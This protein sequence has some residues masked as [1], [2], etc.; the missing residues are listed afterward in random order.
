PHKGITRRNVRNAR[1][2]SRRR[3]MAY[4]LRRILHAC[5]ALLLVSALAFVF[6]ELAPGNFFDE[7]RLNPQ[8]SADSVAG[9][10]AKYGLEQ[11]LAAR[12]G[13]WL[14]SVFRGEFGFSFAYGVPVSALLW[15][16][17]R[18][19]LLLTSIATML[20]W[21]IALLAGALAAAYPS[22]A[23]RKLI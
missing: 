19:T 3:L 23:I 5:A 16:R 20:A 9:L 15:E 14:A 18:N 1:R 17:A 10:K 12:Y 8:I 22:S 21:I 6:T 11:P 4:I 7:M 13:K 2:F